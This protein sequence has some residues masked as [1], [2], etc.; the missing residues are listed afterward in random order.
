L[1]AGAAWRRSFWLKA[2]P[3]S[4]FW[5]C[6]LHGPSIE[7]ARAD[8]AHEGVADR[9]T[10]EVVDGAQLP[11][12]EFDLVTTFDVLHDSADPAAMVRAA[13]Q[14]LAADGTY[15]ASEPNLSPNLEENRNASGRLFYS[16][17]LLYCISVSLGQGGPGIG[18]DSDPEMVRQ[19][20]QGAG[21]SRIRTLPIGGGGFTEMCI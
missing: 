19:W 3:K 10:F 17:S 11:G 16:A 9:A 14:T 1:V 18:S 13:R 21:F 8:A 6:D 7:R 2:F 5:G 15:L 12:R 4:R 20:G